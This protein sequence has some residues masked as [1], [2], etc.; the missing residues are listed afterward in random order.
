M[1][2][3]D[4]AEISACLRRIHV[5]ERKMKHS[6]KSAKK[7]QLELLDLP[8]SILYYILTLVEDK[9]RAAAITASR[10]LAT[11]WE[12]NSR[13][14]LVEPAMPD[15]NDNILTLDTLPVDALL[16][17]FRYLD[18]KTLGR[19]SQVCRRFRALAGSDCL[20]MRL[21]RRALA[22]NQL[23][24]ATKKKSQ[25]KYCAKERV[26]LGHR[27]Q[28]GLHKEL[29]VTVHN[30]KYMPRLQLQR[31]RLW[32]SWGK[33]IWCHPRVKDGAISSATTK[34][35]RGHMD[36]VSK[37]VVSSGMVVSGGRDRS[38][39][40]WSSN[41][42]EFLFARRYCHA[43]EVT[44]LDVTGLGQI[45]V[46]GSR[47]KTLGVWA[48]GDDCSPFLAKQICVGDRVW[49]LSISQETGLTVVGTSGQRGIAPLRL[50]DLSQGQAVL[51]LGR[52]LRNGAGMLDVVW[53]TGSS[54]LSCGYDTCTRLWDTRCGAYVSTWEDPYDESVYCLDT[55]GVNCLVTGTARHGR[56]AVW[57]LRS[58][59]PLYTKYSTPVRRGQSSP[60][61]SLA[62]D[63]ANIYLALDQS[64]NHFAFY[65]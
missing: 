44:A 61:Y 54:L 8:D 41:T 14:I 4:I 23:H 6:Q 46:S 35:L 13:V 37:F 50:F 52:D 60:V 9:S 28:R 48:M 38:I 31:D 11:I 43:G 51:D 47:D 36:D 30:S 16:L 58:S 24:V 15:I 59:K 7:S 33:T 55:D 18:V 40:G 57:D 53:L 21:A 64:L 49:S 10:T 5:V 26:K 12:E 65:A 29:L 39:C 62:M 63:C 3:L 32:V 2:A 19:V 25:V 1:S 34:M 56:I 27:W 20:W 22:S 45:L 42:G 17:I